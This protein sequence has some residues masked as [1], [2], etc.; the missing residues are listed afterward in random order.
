MEIVIDNLSKGHGKKFKYILWPITDKGATGLSGDTKSITLMI[1]H[2][3]TP[4]VK[5]RR[6]TAGVIYCGDMN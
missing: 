5:Y 4:A 2:N 1:R 6:L 3:I